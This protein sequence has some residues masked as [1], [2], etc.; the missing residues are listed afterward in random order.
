MLIVTGTT[1]KKLYRG[2]AKTPIK[3]IKWKKKCGIPET[4]GESLARR[5]ELSVVTT[6]GKSVIGRVLG[7][8]HRVG[9]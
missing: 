4:K 5:E 1:K 8:I 2:I 6:A 7:S 3:E 9:N